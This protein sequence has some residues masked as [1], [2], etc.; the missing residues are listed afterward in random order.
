MKKIL[1]LILCTILVYTGCISVYAKENKA[2]WYC[3][4]KKDHSQPEL[5]ND[6]SFSQNYD[7]FWI[8]ENNNSYE[9]NDK[10]IYLTFDAGYE[11]GNIKKIVEVLKD[12]GVA[13]TF[14]ILDNMILKN[15]ALV[16]R[17]IDD[18]HLI[19]NHTMKHKDMTM[20][21]SKEE[22]AKELE[23]LETL[24]EET[25]G[26]KMSKIYRPPEG[27][28]SETS[29]KWTKELGYKTVMWS[30]AYADW[31]NGKQPQCDYAM[32]KILDNLHNGEVM[33]LHP[34]SGTNA[35]IMKDL[36]IELKSRG[37]RF[38]T[39]DELCKG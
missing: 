22:V 24:Y 23:D 32:K 3:V 2:S 35:E 25:Y 37:F 12:E 38:A 30:F 1:S 31:D 21:G 8:D 36:I 27:K 4:R 9:E 34:T 7:V 13:A 33:L 16:K 10:V 14:F 15:E 17:M 6:L 5:P 20:L 26:I 28:I 19:A 18:G 11:N 29:L 39:V